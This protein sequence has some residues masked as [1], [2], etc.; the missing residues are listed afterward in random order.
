MW[1][2]DWLHVEKER[3]L[4]GEMKRKERKG[5]AKRARNV[6]AFGYRRVFKEVRL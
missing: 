4:L 1:G 2:A 6:C 3:D 5:T